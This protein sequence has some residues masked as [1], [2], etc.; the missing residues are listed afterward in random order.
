MQKGL[1]VE[2][3]ILEG[4]PGGMAPAAGTAAPSAAWVFQLRHTSTDSLLHKLQ[5]ACDSW[6]SAGTVASELQASGYDLLPLLTQFTGTAHALQAVWE[7][8]AGQIQHSELVS[9][10]Q[11]LAEG[12]CAV[13]APA[14][15]TNPCCSNFSGPS[16]TK[17]V[18]GRSCVCG[19]CLVAHF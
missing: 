1:L 16:E 9:S 7:N 10:M 5:A 15:C 17:L 13:A 11:V 18:S 2:Y 8:P 4:R 14:L 3:C 6:L 12:L 19:G